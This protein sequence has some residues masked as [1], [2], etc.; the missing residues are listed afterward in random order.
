MVKKDRLKWLDICKGFAILLVVLGH[1]IDGAT[2]YKDVV[3]MQ[4]L[5]KAI[6]AFHMPLFFFLSGMAYKCFPIAVVDFICVW[7][8]AGALHN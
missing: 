8:H 4:Y 6:Y 7:F 1:V 3:W 2:M 5:Y